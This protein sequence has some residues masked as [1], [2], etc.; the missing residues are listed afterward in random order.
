M[1]IDGPPFKKASTN[2]NNVSTTTTT[3]TTGHDSVT[4]EKRQPYWWTV[5][6][7][8]AVRAKRRAWGYYRRNPTSY[9]QE[10]FRRTNSACRNT[11]RKAKRE[12]WATFCNQISR[13]LNWTVT[14]S[15]NT[16]GF[17]NVY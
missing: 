3:T 17:A 12:A 14:P 2:N 7:L 10:Q 6:C 1:S 4:A 9:K 5:E 15:T 13:D 11:L 16:W 8:E